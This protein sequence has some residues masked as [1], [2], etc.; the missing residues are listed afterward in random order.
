MN[1]NPNQA[2]WEK[3]DFTRIAAPCARA[4]RRSW[5]G[6]ASRRACRC[7]TWAV[8]D[9]TTAL[10]AARRGAEVLGVDIARNLVE[11]GNKA[12][13]GRG[14]DQPPLPAGRRHQLERATDRRFDLVDQHLRRHVRAQA[15][16]VAREM[17]RVTSRRPDR[18]GELDPERPDARR[19]GS[20]DQLGV[21]A[22]A[23]EGFI[24][25]MTWGIEAR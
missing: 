8:G 25:P 7:S 16:D 11:D 17:V 10:P 24:S 21:H 3:G 12:R 18:D 20:E 1:P 2:L 23:P 5:P 15:F 13:A 6:S 22:A 14:P 19:A 9:G 4:A